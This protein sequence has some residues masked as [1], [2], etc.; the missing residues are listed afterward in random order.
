[1]VKLIDADWE[2]LKEKI[3]YG[4]SDTYGLDN[5]PMNVLDNESYAKA[6]AVG[7][8][9]YIKPVNQEDNV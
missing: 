7:G 9:F 3:V 4:H 6:L 2:K 1:M 5:Y 8:E